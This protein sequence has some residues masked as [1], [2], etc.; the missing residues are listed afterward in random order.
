MKGSIVSKP[1]P[2]HWTSSLDGLCM[3]D[4]K[5]IAGDFCLARTPTAEV[6]EAKITARYIHSWVADVLHSTGQ[7]TSE[8]GGVG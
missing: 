2:I 7:Q 8:T 1:C 4:A 3:K 6:S 5:Q